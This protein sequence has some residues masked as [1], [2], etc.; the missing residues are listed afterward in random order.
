[1]TNETDDGTAIPLVD[2]NE[3]PTPVHADDAS[4]SDDTSSSDASID[5][6]ADDADAPMGV[7]VR[8]PPAPDAPV[9]SVDD[10]AKLI[11]HGASVDEAA[12]FAAE[13]SETGE[14]AP[15]TAPA[16][17]ATAL[18][19]LVF[20][21]P[22]PLPAS[23]LREVLADEGHEFPITL[24]K[25]TLQELVEKWASPEKTVGGGMRL[26]ETGAG[27][28]FRTSPDSAQ[29]L[30]RFFAAKPQRLSRAA[31]ETLAIIAYRQ[32]VTRPQ[33]DDIRGV[34]SAGALKNLLDR[35]LIRVLG[36]ADDVGRPLIYGTTRAFLDFFSLSGLSDLP[37]LK[38][39]QD[40]KG[41][42][43]VPE[44]L[45]TPDD[46][47]V[48]VMDLFDPLGSGDLVSKETE[49][50]S[51]KALTAL[52]NALGQAT[53]VTARALAFEKGDVAAADAIPPPARYTIDDDEEDRVAHEA[54]ER[55]V[56]EGWPTDGSAETAPNDATALPPAKDAS[57]LPEAEAKE[58][59]DV[60]D[61]ERTAS[62][63][64]EADTSAVAG[65]VSSASPDDG[66]GHFRTR[67]SDEGSRFT[68]R[69]LLREADAA[70]GVPD[71]TAPTHD[72][73]AGDAEPRDE[74]E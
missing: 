26:L 11:E 73:G 29:F 4:P 37:T 32:P 71:D 53:N 10:A 51:A 20:A 68:P 74:E 16:W 66:H 2:A 22:E 38:D 42:A 64:D 40:L 31:L 9:L 55:H 17:L 36:K 59:S 12:A 35:K 46:G 56:A 33:V 72:D 65:G 5:D 15:V 1:M 3:I 30:R 27:F 50:E 41:G 70:T 44:A 57:E 24:V 60:A 63:V 54:S 6:G 39:Y 45:P 21:A 47:P 25:R 49:E 23:R 8:E 28:A 18:E 14:T 43:G 69:T 48:K 62:V 58:A 34:D 61:T 19:A 13:A 67:R 52:E 7:P